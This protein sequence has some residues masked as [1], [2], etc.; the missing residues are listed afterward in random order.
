MLKSECTS[1]NIVIDKSN[2]WTPALYYINPNGTLSPL[3]GDTLVYYGGKEGST[4]PSR[5]VSAC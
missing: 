1:V 4:A 3:N 5:T 2:Y